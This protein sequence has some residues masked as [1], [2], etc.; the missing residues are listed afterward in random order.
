MKN[1]LSQ[2]NRDVLEEL[3]CSRLL[4]AFDYDG[5]LAPI[6][7]D[8]ERALLRR[9]TRELLAT[10]TKIYQVIVISGRAQADALEK[11]RGLG[12]REVVGNHGIEPRHAT[13]HHIAEVRRWRPVLD[14]CVAPFKGVTIEDKTFSVAIHYRQSREK[15][16]AR[17][18]ILRA[19]AALSDARVVGGKQVVN[20]LPEGA[21]HKGVALE[22]ERNR[23]DCDTAL[24]VGDDE[25]DEDVF[26]L[27]QPGRLLTIRVGAKRSSAAT[28]YIPN[29]RAIDDLLRTL[30]EV[31]R[32]SAL[33]RVPPPALGEVLG[34]MSLM[35][36]VDHALQKTSKRM[37]TAL[38][39]TGP[40]RLVI[41]IVGRF[42]GLPAGELAKLLHVHPSTLT[43]I[44][45]RLERQSLLRRRADPRDGRRS[46]LSLT[47]RG[48]VFD[49]ETEGTVEAAIQQAL[50]RTPQEKLRAAREVLTS[51]AQVLGNSGSSESGCR[52]DESART[53]SGSRHARRPA[54]VSRPG[55]PPSG[56]GR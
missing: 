35:W 26:A 12:V 7:T 1:I 47:D 53:Q 46:L 39:V 4:L 36:G 8:P 21:P 30:I 10:L 28:Y 15:K 56:R 18:A 17:A 19:A 48:R 38:G 31:R 42:P 43:G 55:K 50:E 32:R 11:L 25:T 2:A 41:R 5:T 27:D 20:I 54:G 40:Q 37:E 24:Y 9:E 22:R 16:K 44:L 49:V 3:T 29:Q 51:I 14:E 6:V 33:G 23:L 45:K 34:F 13:D 52:D